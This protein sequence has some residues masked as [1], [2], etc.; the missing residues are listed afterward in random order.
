MNGAAGSPGP[1]RGAERAVTPVVS[2][3]LEVGIVLL[4]VA[5]LST[6]LFGGVVPDYRDAAGDRVAD[7]TLAGA[8]TDLE[9]SVPAA[10]REVRVERAVPLPDSIRGAGYRIVA[11]DGALVLRH[12]TD[13]VGGRT[14]LALPDRVAAVSGTWR[15]G[16]ETVVV[17]T[18]GD[19]GV[20][21]GW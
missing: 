7:R 16:A 3:T 9:R 1:T 4:F 10:A 18:G 6:A 12:P 11:A 15:S 20:T 19:G 13:G 2:K 14:R 17:V 8:A 5:G 21:V